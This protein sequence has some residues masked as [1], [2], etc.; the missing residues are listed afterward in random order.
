M[1]G[2]ASSI[3]FAIRGMACARDG[4]VISN[5]A[6]YH[7]LVVLNVAPDKV[8]R[9]GVLSAHPL[10]SISSK[11]KYQSLESKREYLTLEKK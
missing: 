4:S 10:K 1:F 11:E 8:V 5:G 3:S 2:V 6:A 9:D 7:H